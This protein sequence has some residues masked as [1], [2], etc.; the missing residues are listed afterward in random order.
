MILI[1][2][3]GGGNAC[4]WVRAVLKPEWLGQGAVEF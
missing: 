3:K 1:G 4:V 2:G